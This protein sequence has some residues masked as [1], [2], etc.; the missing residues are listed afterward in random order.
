MSLR[1]PASTHGEGTRLPARIVEHLPGFVLVAVIAMA[2]TFIADH[3]GGPVLL[4][5]LLIGVSMSALADE[6]RVSTGLDISAG[7]F[8]PVGIALAGLS[9][10]FTE[11]A[12]LG[13]VT[14]AITLGVMA[15]T[16][17]AG[18]LVGGFLGSPLSRS[19]IYSAAVAV[20]GGSAALAMACL[21]PQTAQT[22]RDT[23][24]AI[25]VVTGLSTAAMILYP[26]VASALML[27][28]A[29]TGVFLGATIHAVAQAVAAGFSVSESAGEVATVVK[30]VRVAGLIPVVFAFS[31]Y[32]R[33][34]QGAPGN[35]EAERPKLVPYFLIGFAACI[36]ATNLVS[37]P[38]PLLEAGAVMSK[39]M[40]LLAVCA[41][42]VQTSIR[43][44]FNA[45][46]ASILMLG[47][48]TVFLAMACLALLAIF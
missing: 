25:V 38:V 21:F 22:R 35:G 20:C 11:I 10:T 2:S 12:A 17:L 45:G 30:L 18:L 36:L 26:A 48:L 47:G 8:L 32:L 43:N 37:L 15:L 3:Y 41:I 16:I 19:A 29:D 23:T 1:P 28:E 31:L 6:P 9:V 27:D 5:A 40:I 24:L 33:T 39:T 14:V 44:M 34:S 13:A 46:S 4:Y 42:G 7:L